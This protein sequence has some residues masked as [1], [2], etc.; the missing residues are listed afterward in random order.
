MQHRPT[1]CDI[2]DLINEIAHFVAANPMWMENGE[3][4]RRMAMA[5]SILASMSQPDMVTDEEYEFI[6]DIHTTIKERTA[7]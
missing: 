7:S 5:Y 4:M 2:S 3:S 1:T 6:M